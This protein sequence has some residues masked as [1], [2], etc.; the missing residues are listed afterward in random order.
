MVDRVGCF[1]NVDGIG[2]I[3]D[4][5][6]EV[7]EEVF[8]YKLIDGGVFM[9]YVWDDGVDD[10]ENCVDEYVDLVVLGVDGWVDEG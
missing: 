7:E 2:C 9:S 6:V 3:G 1:D 4:G 5:D 8:S 10:D